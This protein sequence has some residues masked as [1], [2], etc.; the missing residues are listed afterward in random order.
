LS[1]R[2]VILMST[3]DPEVNTTPPSA[4]LEE[5]GWELQG[6]WGAFLGTPIGPHHF[7]TAKH[8]GGAVG[9]VFVLAGI[10]YRTIASFDDP[11]TDLRIWQVQGPLPAQASLYD[12]SDELGQS[13]V[14]FGRGTQRGDAVMVQTTAGPE[15]RGWHWGG[16]DG[17]RRW[18]Q[19][20]VES[21]NDG[22]TLET[23]DSPEQPTA[24]G[25]LLR[26]SF[27][28][29][30][31]PN[32]AHLSGGDSGGGV[33]IQDE[34]NWKLAGINYAVDG[35]YNL[36]DLGPGFA[37]AIFDQRGLYAGKEGDWTV[38]AD[39]G[40]PQPG[41]FY[42]TRISSRIAWINSVLANP[43]PAPPILQWASDPAGPYSELSADWDAASR[44]V[45]ISLPVNSRYYRLSA[46][47]QLTIKSIMV[48]GAQLVLSY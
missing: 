38:I 35:S 6:D 5:S 34:G 12:R 28:A 13:L 32:E 24:V 47:T 20:V 42:A 36:T 25:Q 31:A 19:N 17:R 18:G 45:A 16:A 40:S 8:V 14:V 15:L 1:T 3:A 48:H 41:A 2:A 43:D 9:D 29:G 4:E 46:A 23:G 7:V 10:G 27:D 11:E 33:F 26:A 39:A 30:G 37:A 21:I 44:A 22:D